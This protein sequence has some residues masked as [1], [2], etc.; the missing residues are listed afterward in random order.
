MASKSILFFDA[1]TPQWPQ[2]A[3]AKCVLLYQTEAEALAVAAFRAECE[4][5]EPTTSCTW[6]CSTDVSQRGRSA[7][8]SASRAASTQAAPRSG[9]AWRSS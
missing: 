4:A 9:Q 6:G 8:G 5:T 1:Y 7:P 2:I 3:T